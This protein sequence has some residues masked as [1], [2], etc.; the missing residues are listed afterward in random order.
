M[1]AMW[2][3]HG[4]PGGPAPG[5]VSKPYSLADARARLAEV[6]GNPRFAETFFARYVEGREAPDY[7]KLLERAG[8][9]LRRRN[10]GRAWLGTVEFQNDPDGLGLAG[11]TAPGS[12]AYA[13]G[14]DRGDV[15]VSAD[16]R[17][18]RSA[19]QLANALAGKKPGETVRID[20]LR[21]GQPASATATLAEDPALE[22]VAV[23][24]TGM[25]LTPAQKQF[26]AAWLSSRV[27]R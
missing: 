27:Q 10:A 21:R 26:R 14:L 20:F 16:E 17:P 6:S 5:L 12:P 23:E 13:A 22:V 25:S 7:A 2:R 18:I 1:R 3:A 24:S 8:L 15:I 9:I 4:R 11:L 19:D